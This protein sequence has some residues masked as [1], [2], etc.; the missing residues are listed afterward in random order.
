MMKREAVFAILEMRKNELSERGVKSMAVFGS[1]ARNE[2]SSASDVDMLVEFDRPIGL[3]EFI[4][5]KITLENWFHCKVDLV[6]PDA[7]HPA[8]RE[9]ILG[10]AIYVRQSIES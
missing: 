1:V 8:L 9:K 7:L 2:A 6:T 5:L 4:R 10:E 3:F